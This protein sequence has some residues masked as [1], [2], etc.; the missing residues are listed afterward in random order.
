MKD[1]KI[2]I[3]TSG[4]DCAGLNAV[5]RAAGISIFRNI[6][7]A[8]LIG[9]PEGYG[10]LIDGESVKLRPRDIEGIL[11]EGGT[12]L[13]SSRQPFKQMQIRG[14]DGQTKLEK[15]AANYKKLGLDCLI[16]IGGAGTHKNAALLMREGC[17]VIGVPKTIDN[18]KP[19]VDKTSAA[20]AANE[21]TIKAPLVGT[22]YLQPKPNKPAYIKIGD[23]VHKGDVVCV[24]E[25]MKMLTEVK[26]D[27]DGTVK[28]VNVENGDLVEFNQPLFTITEG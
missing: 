15:M 16:A 6:K 21:S 17:K 27:R 9:I 20:K 11:A 5:I 13:G 4:G 25:A 1:M 3:L 23:Q 7:G 8:E 19:T 18:A 12:L 10:G 24:I 14:E 28:A 2:G 26:S 22:V